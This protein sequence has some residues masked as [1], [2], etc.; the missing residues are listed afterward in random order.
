ML[1]AHPALAT[2]RHDRVG[3][4]R[5]DTCRDDDGEIGRDLA[6]IRPEHDD[7]LVTAEPRDGVG[8][9]G[10]VGEPARHLAQRRVTHRVALSVVDA[11]EPVEVDDQHRGSTGAL[12]GQERVELVLHLAPVRQAGEFVVGCGMF[13]QLL[14]LDDV[15][16]VAGDDEQLRGW[17]VRVAGEHAYAPRQPGERTIGF[18]HTVLEVGNLAVRE[19]GGR[20]D[21]GRQAG[22]VLERDDIVETGAT[23]HR[24]GARGEADQRRGVAV[25]TG[26]GAGGDV[27]D[28]DRVR[29]RRY[30]GLLE[31]VC[32]AE[33][34]LDLDQFVDVGDHARRAHHGTGLVTFGAPPGGEPGRVAAVG[35]HPAITQVDGRALLDEVLHRR[36]DH[37]AVGVGDTVDQRAAAEGDRLAGHPAHL[38][39]LVADD[40][41]PSAVV[42]LPRAGA[43]DALCAH[44]SVMVGLDRGG[45]HRLRR[46]T[47][48]Q[49]S[50]DR[51]RHD[52]AWPAV[53]G[54]LR[55]TCSIDRAHA[56]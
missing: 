37:L 28:V 42:E 45:P 44:E 10:G 40:Q 33:F 39:Q 27:V 14:H 7:E 43:A 46:L 54:S 35:T 55:H 41:Q 53:A 4:R 21:G 30:D 47:P 48:S 11:L 25:R 52:V 6:R 32:R 2:L 24:D 20:V 23:E 19:P 3:Q 12:R 18:V 56:I 17:S 1:A 15:R 34:L 8:R 49:R 31:R 36:L 16:D 5:L 9:A 51:Q 22:P 26:E 13:E 50:P 38:E 29:C